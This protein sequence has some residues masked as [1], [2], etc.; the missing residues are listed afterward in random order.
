MPPS[1][2]AG[3]D[4]ELHWG[5]KHNSSFKKMKKK[6]YSQD[7]GE[8]FEIVDQKYRDHFDVVLGWCRYVG[9]DLL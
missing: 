5:G 9:A 4:G 2:L 8:Q 6:L 7:F 1:P 3:T